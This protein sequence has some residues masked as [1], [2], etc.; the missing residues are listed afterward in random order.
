MAAKYLEQKGYTVI[1][2][3]YRSRFGE[4][5]LIAENGKYIVFAEVKLRRDR[6][7]ANA[8]EFV[9][10]RKQKRII[11]TARIWLSEHDTDLQPRFDVIEIYASDDM[12][13]TSV[14]HI[15]SAFEVTE[16]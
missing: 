13:L 16:E 9:D 1:D 8:R 11:T 7:F 15:E 4:I 12:R 14:E 3:G 5:D 10:G 2:K 6:A